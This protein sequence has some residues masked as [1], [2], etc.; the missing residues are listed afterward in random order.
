MKSISV[1]E[2]TLAP[3]LVTKAKNIPNIRKPNYT[4]LRYPNRIIRKVAHISVSV[5]L[6]SS[7]L[8]IYQETRFALINQQA[9]T[10]VPWYT[11]CQQFQTISIV[12]Q[13]SLLLEPRGFSLSL[14]ACVQQ[15][16]EMHEQ[17]RKRVCSIEREKQFKIELASTELGAYAL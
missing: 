17:Y 13:W 11:P 7:L 1:S 10:S 3:L 5:I 4:T 15:P 9:I 16:K 2:R 6:Y 14:P 8:V 12:S